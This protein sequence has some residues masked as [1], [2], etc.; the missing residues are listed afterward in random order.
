[1]KY[2]LFVAALFLALSGYFLFLHV[3]GGTAPAPA[4]VPAV[5]LIRVVTRMA[6][7]FLA[8]LFLPFSL[9]R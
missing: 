4:I 7:P 9:P 1:M 8:H 3:P 2:C 6:L 5:A